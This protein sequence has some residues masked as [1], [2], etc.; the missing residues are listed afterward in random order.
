MITKDL[1][2]ERTE[3]VAEAIRDTVAES[4]LFQS[5]IV[6]QGY[7]IIVEAMI[8]PNNAEAISGL[9]KMGAIT[10]VD[11]DLPPAVALLK[12]DSAAALEFLGL[13]PVE[14]EPYVQQLRE[15]AD[16]ILEQLKGVL[17][18]AVEEMLTAE[19]E[20]MPVAGKPN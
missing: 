18:P 3:E 17:R 13:T 1:I 19:L 4:G 9:R 6:A 12:R 2:E 5:A 15:Y 10:N 8:H 14:R 20:A 7:H 11:K 16:P